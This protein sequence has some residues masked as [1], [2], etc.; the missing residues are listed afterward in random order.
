MFDENN[1]S[2]RP[3][4]GVHEA[5]AQRGTE[6]AQQHSWRASGKGLRR[7]PQ[8]KNSHQMEFSPET[9]QFRA[10]QGPGSR[11]AGAV[12]GPG[13]SLVRDL[14]ARS[15]SHQVPGKVDGLCRGLQGLSVTHQVPLVGEG[16]A[17]DLSSGGRQG[18]EGL[19]GKAQGTGAECPAR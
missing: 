16:A 7:G 10:S 17:G 2:A 4:R 15:C 11:G 5:E 1:D 9:R 3:Q 12:R 19:D 6:V 14:A 18:A 8:E 13:T